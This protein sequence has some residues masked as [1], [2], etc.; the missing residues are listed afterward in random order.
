M[1]IL[2]FI[3]ISLLFEVRNEFSNKNYL[4]VCTY[5]ISEYFKRI[6]VFEF[7]KIIFLKDYYL[8]ILDTDISIKFIKEIMVR[9][10]IRNDR[11]IHM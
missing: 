4:N 5:K 10:I 6:I 9:T 11:L 3:I 7:K 1:Y 2:S 8:S